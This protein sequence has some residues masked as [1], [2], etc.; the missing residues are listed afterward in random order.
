[1]K[2]RFVSKLCFGF[3]YD[4]ELNLSELIGFSVMVFTSKSQ[5]FTLEM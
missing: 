3:F 4:Y 2:F 5:A 1:M